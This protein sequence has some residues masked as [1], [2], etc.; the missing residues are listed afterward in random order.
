MNS[1]AELIASIPAE[2]S[3]RDGLVFIAQALDDAKTAT[4]EILARYTGS[5]LPP[6]PWPQHAELRTAI[7]ALDGGRLLLNK[8]IEAGYGD[9]TEPKAGPL[10]T[11]LSNGIR[12]L[13]RE[14]GEMQQRMKGVK[15]EDVPRLA[16]DAAKKA[17]GTSIGSWVFIAGLFYVLSNLDDA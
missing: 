5:T 11:R 13:Y 8:A 3:A 10:G 14:V 6:P 9:K 4:D 1:A 15:L 7:D 2:V 17:A 16:L 12:A